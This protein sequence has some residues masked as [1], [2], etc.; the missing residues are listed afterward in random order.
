MR[1]EAEFGEARGAGGVRMVQ[2]DRL[3]P[4][5]KDFTAK[6]E[7]DTSDSTIAGFFRIG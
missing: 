3:L 1:I 7:L 6:W 2:A 4:I 5:V